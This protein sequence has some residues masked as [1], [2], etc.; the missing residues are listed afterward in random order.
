[1][2]VSFIDPTPPETA[3]ATE[4]PDVPWLTGDLSHSDEQSRG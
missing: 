2:T 4:F 3:G 1:M